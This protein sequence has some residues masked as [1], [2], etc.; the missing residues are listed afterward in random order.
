[1]LTVEVASEQAYGICGIWACVGDGGAS[2]YQDSGSQDLCTGLW[3][4]FNFCRL[5]LTPVDNIR[6]QM[7]CENLA[8]EKKT[9]TVRATG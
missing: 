1:M 9:V 5:S 2:A 7:R 3:S 6:C 4:V 8:E